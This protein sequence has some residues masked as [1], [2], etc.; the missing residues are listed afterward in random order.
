MYK[1]GNR[2]L[3][4]LMSLHSATIGLDVFNIYIEYY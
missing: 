3:W 2:P 1:L 4:R